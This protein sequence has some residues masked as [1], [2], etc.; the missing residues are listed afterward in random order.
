MLNVYVLCHCFISWLKDV[1]SLFLRR[2]N[3]KDHLRFMS[4]ISPLYF[5]QNPS[6][7]FYPVVYL[8]R[9]NQVAIGPGIKLLFYVL[10]TVIYTTVWPSF[11]YS[12]KATLKTKSKIRV[13]K[14]KLTRNLTPTLVHQTTCRRMW[15]LWNSSHTLNDIAKAINLM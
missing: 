5:K 12:L 13:L 14:I 15:T 4:P 1:F 3:F 9:C 6:S 2:T 8:R 11:F 7:H 10:M